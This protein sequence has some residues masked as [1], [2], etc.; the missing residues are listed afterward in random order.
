MDAK[1]RLQS[2][3]AL[4]RV[5]AMVDHFGRHRGNLFA[6]AITYAGFLAVFPLLA[7]AFAVA[8]YVAR[9]YPDAQ[10]LV[11]DAIDQLLPGIV[12]ESPGEGAIAIEDISGASGAL[13]VVGFATLLLTGINWLGAMRESLDGMGGLPTSRA[14]GFLKSK[15]KDLTSLILVGSILIASVSATSLLRYLAGPVGAWL[16]PLGGIAVSATLFYTLYR[17]VLDAPIEKRWAREGALLAAVGF[18]AIKFVFT[19]IIGGVGGTPFA[20][21]AIAITILVWINYFA[22]VSLFGAAWAHTRR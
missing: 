18:E 14:P 20:P 6:G 4:S 9:V 11:I 19:S 10:E 21:L 1:A 17:V 5:K 13:G 3:V 8:G 15:L 12:S 16:A 22:K 2:S 7:I